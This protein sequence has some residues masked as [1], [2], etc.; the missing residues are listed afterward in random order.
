MNR[1]VWTLLLALPLFGPVRV[2]AIDGAFESLHQSGKAFASV[3]QA[4]SPSVVNIQI[5]SG[6][7]GADMVRAP[8]PFGEPAMR[9][10]GERNEPHQSR[11]MRFAA[12]STSYKLATDP[13]N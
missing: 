2:S 4:V 6:S 12:L 5:E 9:G 1:Y 3:A 10:C 13:A 11:K 7:P 8:L